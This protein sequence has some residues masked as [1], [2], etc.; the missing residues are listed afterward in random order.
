MSS[1]SKI[2][3][4]TTANQGDTQPAS[5][6][7][8]SQ[9]GSVYQATP[10]DASENESQG[11]RIGPKGEVYV[12]STTLATDTKLDDIIT[13]LGPL[14][15][16][17]TLGAL[18]AK[19]T[20]CDT[21]S[22]T[23]IS[24][25]LPTGAATEATLATVAGDTTSLDGKVTA[26][27][28]GNVSIAS[29]A[30]PAGAATEATLATVAGD[31]TS[32]DGKV[33]A[34]DTGNVTIS[35]ALP[36]GDNN[37]GN[38]DLASPIPAGTNN[39]GNVDIASALPAG[40]NT[41]GKVDVNQLD[42]VETIYNDFS[43]SNLPGSASSPLQLVASLSSAVSKI[44]IADTGGNFMEI[45]SGGSGSEVRE[46]LIGPGSD[47]TIELSL[48]SATRVS[49]RRIDSTSAASVGAIAIN[50]IG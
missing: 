50:F 39:I 42:V 46:A 36:A 44:Q 4:V 24:S 40:T 22:V 7:P 6:Y 18:S 17:A 49:I 31:T 20:A 10:A 43:S 30:L 3:E 21:G 15:L 37:I 19:I 34:C 28:T 47:S 2:T 35:A 33:T 27:D 26:C 14:A 16:E 13:A 45:M 32:L 41:I 29:S 25:A 5:G 48:P 12:V 11:I 1:Q 23:I 8:L 38:V 9:I